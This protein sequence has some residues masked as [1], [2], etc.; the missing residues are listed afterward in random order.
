V[1]QLHRV[2]ENPRAKTVLLAKNGT[3]AQALKELDDPTVSSSAFRQIRSATRALGDMNQDEI[4]QLRTETAA[5]A[6]LL[7]LNDALLKAARIAKVAL[8]RKA[9]P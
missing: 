9:T 6:L 2:L 3:F 1:R 5:Q 4:E 7:G 8:P